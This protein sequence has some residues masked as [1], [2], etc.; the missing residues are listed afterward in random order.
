MT[1]RVRWWL[2]DELNRDGESKTAVDRCNAMKLSELQ[3]CFE[4]D[5]CEIEI[6]VS[7]KDVLR[8]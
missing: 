5:V 6:K 2:T 4:R 8:E 3:R 1:E 7:K